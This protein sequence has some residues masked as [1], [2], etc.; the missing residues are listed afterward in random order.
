[1]ITSVLRKEI[2]MGVTGILVV[3]NVIVF[4]I[5]SL[6]GR[7]EEAEYM[8]EHGAMYG[9]YVVM[10]GEY[11]RF[12][13]S[14]FLHFGFTHL[15]NNM[16]TLIV[17]GKHVEPVVGKL[18]F[19]IIYLVSGLGG[20]LLSFAGSFITTENHVSAGASGAIFG[21]TGSLLALTIMLRGHV[22]D[23][24]GRKVLLLIAINLYLGFT[25]QGV[26]NLAHIG[27]LLCGFLITFPVASIPKR[28]CHNSHRTPQ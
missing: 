18:R 13:T 5:L 1:M 27:G 12:F 3:L 8:L 16:I 14:M 28:L 7:T 11:Y 19:A 26:D 21:L 22:G 24:S 6:G 25:N 23:I 4:V 10:Y 2:A 17:V 15:M 20:S 9:P